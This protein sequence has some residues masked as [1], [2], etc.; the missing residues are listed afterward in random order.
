MSGSRSFSHE[1]A[2]LVFCAH[3]PTVRE[4]TN[5]HTHRGVLVRGE[6][7]EALKPVQVLEVL[8]WV[9]HGGN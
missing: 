1:S 5:D 2:S 4:V 6:A 3:E 8:F 7:F 9:R